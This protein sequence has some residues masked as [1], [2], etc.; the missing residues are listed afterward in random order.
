MERGQTADRAGREGT[1]MTRIHGRCVE[2]N[3]TGRCAEK[4]AGKCADQDEVYLGGGWRC[5][6]RDGVV[7]SGVVHSGAS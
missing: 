2:Y 5:A 1:N 7:S 3:E 6:E 4:C